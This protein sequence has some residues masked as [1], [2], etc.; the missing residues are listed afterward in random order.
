MPRPTGPVVYVVG[1]DGELVAMPAPAAPTDAVAMDAQHRT[2]TL[3]DDSAQMVQ[4]AGD[5]SADMQMRARRARASG[6]YGEYV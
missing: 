5:F 4:E 1:D 6:D 3:S 2:A